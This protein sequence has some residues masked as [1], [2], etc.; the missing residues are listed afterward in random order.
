MFTKLRFDFID[1]F[2][3]AIANV[4]AF[5]PGVHHR[6]QSMQ[7]NFHHLPHGAAFQN[8]VDF[9]VAVDVL[10]KPVNS[11]LNVILQKFR[12]RVASAGDF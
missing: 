4:F 2:I 3:D 7:V 8:N 6:M 12:Y 1:G 10:I 9:A 11:F 5:F